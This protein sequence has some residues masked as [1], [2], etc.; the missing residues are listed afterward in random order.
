MS[1]PHRKVRISEMIE[2]LNGTATEDDMK[3]I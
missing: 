2:A 3:D 1:F